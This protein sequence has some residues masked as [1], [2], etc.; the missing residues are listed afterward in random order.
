MF[1]FMKYSIH[2]KT[3]LSQNG[4]KLTAQRLLV[5][6]LF[7]SATES[8]N[9]YDIKKALSSIN[10]KI[11]IVS[12]YRILS[13]LKKLNLV[14]EISP[15]KFVRCQKFTCTNLSHCHHQF[16]CNSCHKTEEIHVDD[17]FFIN[18]LGKLYP[19]LLI[20]SHSFCFEGL[21]E[22]CREIS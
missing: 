1:L 3:N 15:G 7:E 12:I 22:K 8:R 18:D 17:N 5:I 4:Y 11:D 13:L 20:N 9:A 6:D 21:C 16:I 19:K 2:A 14:H 10:K